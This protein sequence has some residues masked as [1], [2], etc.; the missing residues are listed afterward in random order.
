M[1]KWYVVQGRFEFPIYAE[2]EDDAF[3]QAEEAYNAAGFGIIDDSSQVFEFHT[4]TDI[5]E[6]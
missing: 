3:E 2:N 6:E 5:V 4:S 1:N